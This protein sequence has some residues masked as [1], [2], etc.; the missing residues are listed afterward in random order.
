MKKYICIILIAITVLCLP[1]CTKKE[2]SEEEIIEMAKIKID[3]RFMNND[4]YDF[5]NYEVYP[6][7]DENEYMRH[8]LVEFEPSCFMFIEVKYDNSE[9]GKIKFIKE[10]YGVERKWN[11]YEYIDGK[12]VFERDENMQR[13]YYDV[14]PYEMYDKLQ[15]KKYLIELDHQR[16]VPAVK[17]G[18]LYLNLVSMSYFEYN[19]EKGAIREKGFEV[20]QL[21]FINSNIL[22]GIL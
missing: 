4:K 12:A 13:I 6:L 9:K 21:S 22:G 17:E 8:L 3:N 11:K 20:L 5:T 19:G 10:S 2:Y 7:Y 18:N 16:Y 15:E 14:S 1:G